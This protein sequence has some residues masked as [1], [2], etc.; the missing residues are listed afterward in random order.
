MADTKGALPVVPSTMPRS[1][2]A[3]LQAEQLIQV[4]APPRAA[5]AMPKQV[6]TRKPFRLLR[7][8]RVWLSIAPGSRRLG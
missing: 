5:L 4:M 7:L 1:H 6:L 3:H 8:L 2:T